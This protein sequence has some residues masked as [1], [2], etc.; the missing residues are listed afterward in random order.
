MGKVFTHMHCSSIWLRDANWVAGWG[1]KSKTP[2]GLK[3]LTKREE[4]NEMTPS[5]PG[6][7]MH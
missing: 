1:P 6:T 5:K 3:S 4:K 2:E 7:D